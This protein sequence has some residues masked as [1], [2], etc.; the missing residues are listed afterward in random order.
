LVPHLDFIDNRTKLL[1]PSE[2]TAED[3]HKIPR[4]A[5]HGVPRGLKLIIDVETFDYAYFPRA[6]RGVKVSLA[7]GRDKGVIN[8]DGYY[9][10][11]G[12]EI[13]SI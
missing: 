2:Y 5:H 6:S 1:D 13:K 4:G 11:P 10:S 12:N 3:F 7:D 9:L 8:Q